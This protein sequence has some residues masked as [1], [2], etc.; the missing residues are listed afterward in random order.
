MTIMSY[1]QSE[2]ESIK[3]EVVSK[4]TNNNLN[5]VI[6]LKEAESIEH[7]EESI[8]SFPHN[9]RQ[10]ETSTS[11]R[12]TIINTPKSEISSL[13]EDTVVVKLPKKKLPKKTIGFAPNTTGL[14]RGVSAP[15]ANDLPCNATTIPLPTNGTSSC[16]TQT[17]GN[18]DATSDYYGGC[19]QP[20]HNSV[21]YKFEITAGNDYLTAQLNPLGAN[22]KE[23]EALLISG[24]C[25]GSPAGY[26]V[27]TPSLIDDH[28]ALSPFT[29]EFWDLTPGW[30]YLMF[31]TQPGSNLLSN[32]EICFTQS[33]EP[34][35]VTGPE[36]DCFGA[37]PVCDMSYTQVNSYTGYWDTDE[38]PNGVNCLEGG[39][40]NSVWYVFTPTSTGVFAFTLQTANDYDWAL[41]DLTAI[42]GCGNV[43]T[44]APLRCNYSATN[45]NTGMSASGGAASVGAIGLP[46]STTLVVT[47]GHNYALLVDNYTGDA[48]G[49]F[50]DFSASAASIADRPTADPPTGAKP[51]MT[52]VTSNCLSNTLVI[53]MSEL[54]QCLTIRPQDFI[55][56]NT[57]TSTNF[58]S[59]IVSVTGQNCD[60]N[61]YTKYIEITHNGS[62]TTGTY[63]ITFAPTVILADKCGNVVN[64]ASSVS[65]DYLGT[66]TLTSS[67]ATVCYGASIT[68]TAGGANGYNL[69]TINPG[70]M[71]DPR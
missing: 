38:I 47:E 50:L 24:N 1:S 26:F 15:P 51:T 45:G 14:N 40:H 41:W 32:F 63:S 53:E 46:W 62:L 55:I 59:A 11:N 5:V 68:L 60:A 13:I 10:I 64:T 20:N 31:S 30:Y 37:I 25:T 21:W 44:S 33:P 4:I 34:E 17:G 9:E 48:N 2:I 65:F 66:L 69:Y 39:E 16:V 22:G 70:N 12:N 61:E 42:G 67:A 49:Y 57:T 3:E 54:V 36:Q 29:F 6:Q 23:I 28:C 58:T 8:S 43:G 27:G 56:T 19:I 18:A 35:F 7:A 52:S 71:T